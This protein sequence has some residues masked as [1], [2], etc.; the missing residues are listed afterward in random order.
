MI[1]VLVSITARLRLRTLADAEGPCSYRVSAVPRANEAYMI[2]DLETCN[3]C[4][5]KD[6]LL[7]EVR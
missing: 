7:M 2:G 6:R 4:Q 5:T 1:E 3:E